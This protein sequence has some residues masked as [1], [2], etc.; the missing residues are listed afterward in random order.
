[1]G[2]HGENDIWV[3]KLSPLSDVV[4]TMHQSGYIYPNR[5]VGTVHF[6]FGGGIGMLS[7]SNALGQTVCRSNVTG[8]RT[9]SDLPNGL[10]TYQFV[11]IDGRVY[12][13]KV[14]VQR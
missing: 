7:I 9:T 14:V 6:D 4:G 8:S 5:S 3:V 10:L 12:S 11:T 2:N 1:M 13:G